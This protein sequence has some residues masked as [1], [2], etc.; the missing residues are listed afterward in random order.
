M[1]V[2]S[3]R[4]DKIQFSVFSTVNNKNYKVVVKLDDPNKLR[5][6]K[7]KRNLLKVTKIPIDGKIVYVNDLFTD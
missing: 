6:S 7:I 5:V 3:S 2:S 4:M 1:S